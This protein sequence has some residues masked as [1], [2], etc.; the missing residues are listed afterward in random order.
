MTIVW[1]PERTLQPMS[2][3]SHAAGVRYSYRY[4]R[5]NRD[6]LSVPPE[7][8]RTC[9]SGLG[10]VDTDVTVPV[11]PIKSLLVEEFP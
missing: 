7:A 8:N 4:S 9:P 11:W 1:R 3:R 6:A 2:A 5:L 10:T